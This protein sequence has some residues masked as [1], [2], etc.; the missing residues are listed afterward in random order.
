MRWLLAAW[1]VWCPLLS[2]HALAPQVV[3][4]G[5]PTHVRTMVHAVLAEELDWRMLPGQTLRV[6]LQEYAEDETTFEGKRLISFLLSLDIDGAIEKQRVSLLVAPD[7]NQEQRM[8]TE[9]RAIVRQHVG[10]WFQP[11]SDLHIHHALPSGYWVLPDADVLSVGSRLAIVDAQGG[12]IGSMVVSDRFAHE[13]DDSGVVEVVQLLP[14]WAARPV[15][16]GM[17]LEKPAVQLDLA[18]APV[19]SLDR[20]SVNLPVS[21]PLPGSLLT[22]SLQAD[23]AWNRI[24]NSVEALWFAGLSR[25]FSLGELSGNPDVIGSW[26]TNLRVGADAHLGLGARFAPEG[27][28]HFLYGAKA[29]FHVLHQADRH[30]QWGFAAGYRHLAIIDA[31]GVTGIQDSAEGITISPMCAWM[32]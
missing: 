28:V 15:T 8:A 16:A 22:L 5:E 26:W 3:V 32:W 23:V 29:G 9:V 13:S 24:D 7:E 25:S 1:L 11:F 14:L 4:E 20:I 2:L 19:I 12:T 27:S 30:F 31:A 21:L 6:S 17:G 10:V 18:F